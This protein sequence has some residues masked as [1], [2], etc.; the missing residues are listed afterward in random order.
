MIRAK[1]R[2][3][4][5]ACMKEGRKNVNINYAIIINWRSKTNKQWL[6]RKSGCCWW[7]GRGAKYKKRRRSGEICKAYFASFCVLKINDIYSFSLTATA[8]KKHCPSR[9]L[10]WFCPPCI[11]AMH[12]SLPSVFLRLVYSLLFNV[13]CDV[14]SSMLTDCCACVASKWAMPASNDTQ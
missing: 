6:H 11:A 3:A 9:E 5:A 8:S 4:V 1:G 14:K 13:V 12:S 7:W 10:D 2:V